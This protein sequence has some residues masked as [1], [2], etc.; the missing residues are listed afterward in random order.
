M[1]TAKGWIISTIELE[2]VI[3]IRQTD[4]PTDMDTLV[5]LQLL[6]WGTE[7]VPAHQLIAT[8]RNGGCVFVAESQ[9]EILGFCYGFS[10]GEYLFS[11]LLVVHPKARGQGLGRRLKLAQLAWAREQNF[12]ELRWTFDPLRV[13]NARLNLNLPGTTVAAYYKNYYGTMADSLNE[14]DTD[15]L[16]VRWATSEV[17]PVERVNVVPLL[18]EGKVEPPRTRGTWVSLSLPSEYPM[19]ADK[20]AWLTKLRAAFR[21]AFEAGYRGVE[22]TSEGYLLRPWS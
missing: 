1:P 19:G 18:R 8:A 15:R 4:R 20:Q 6:V 5:A 14:G 22:F 21:W 3:S 2:L 13:T 17:S 9:G 12:A 7:A 10:A 16:E 11:H